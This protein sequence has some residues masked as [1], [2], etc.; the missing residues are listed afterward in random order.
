MLYL[1]YNEEVLSNHTFR[2]LISVSG[3]LPR[4]RGDG[5]EPSQLYGVPAAVKEGPASCTVQA[6]MYSSNNP[7]L[8][9]ELEM[10]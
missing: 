6:D 1:W 5:R 7:H 8:T 9:N 2:L 3:P 10:I 4:A